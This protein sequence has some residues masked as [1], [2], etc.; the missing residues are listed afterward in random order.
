MTWA[1]FEALAVEM[2][3][4]S[5]AEQAAHPMAAFV[6]AVSIWS[7]RRAAGDKVTF[8]EVLDEPFEWVSVKQPQ[9]RSPGKRK[10]AKKAPAKKAAARPPRTSA[11]AAEH[12]ESQ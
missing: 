9:D 5:P 12:P 4:L 2:S 11:Q 6:M 8:A 7:S 3:G 10:G 1:Q